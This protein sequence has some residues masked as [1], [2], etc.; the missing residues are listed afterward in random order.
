MNKNYLI[1]QINKKTD[2]Y[3]KKLSDI[4]KTLL[5]VKKHVGSYPYEYL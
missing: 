1:F 4:I 3:N 2:N 5:V